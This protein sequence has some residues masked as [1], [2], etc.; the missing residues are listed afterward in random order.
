MGLPIEA[1][2]HRILFLAAAK[3][4]HSKELY[5]YLANKQ[6]SLHGRG[7]H[8]VAYYQQKKDV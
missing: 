6:S 5:V 1:K 4:W 7:C 2:V 8:A 3:V